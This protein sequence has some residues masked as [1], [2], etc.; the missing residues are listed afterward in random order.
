[1]NNRDADRQSYISGKSVD[2]GLSDIFETSKED[3][4]S[5]PGKTSLFSKNMQGVSNKLSWFV[6]CWMKSNWLRG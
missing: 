4:D 2:S 6:G 1:M 5:I 3:L